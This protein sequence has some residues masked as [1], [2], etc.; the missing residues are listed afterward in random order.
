[1]RRDNR[2]LKKERF[3]QALADG[4]SVTFSAAAAGI[5]RQGIYRWREADPA[6]AERWDEA[7]ESGGDV[8]EEFNLEQARQGSRPAIYNGLKMHRRIPQGVELSGPNGAPIA[9]T[10]AD[11]IRS[12]YLA[13]QGRLAAADDLSALPQAPEDDQ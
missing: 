8:Y 9:F 7:W 1:M 12:A 10:L 11:L 13:D 2:D 5:S 6:F 4:H 3:L